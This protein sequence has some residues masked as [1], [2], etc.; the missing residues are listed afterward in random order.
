M[1]SSWTEDFARQL[2]AE[3]L[4][5]IGEVGVIGQLSLIDPSE[6]KEHY[7][8]SYLPEYSRY[9]IERGTRWEKSEGDG[10]YADAVDSKTYGFYATSAETAVVLLNLAYLHALVPSFGLIFEENDS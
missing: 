3:S 4:I 7:I 9:V 6:A 5:Y 2:L 8:A 10:D 1:K